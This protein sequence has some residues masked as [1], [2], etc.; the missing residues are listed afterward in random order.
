MEFIEATTDDIDILV[1][2]W[3][4]LA[5]AMEA[6]DELN[7][8]CY[9][10]VDEVSGGGFRALLDED[11]VTIYL[12][13]HEDKTI[14]YITLRKGHHPSREYSQYLRIVDL[15]I[16]EG[17]RNQGHGTEV[18]KRVKEIA[19]DQTCDYLKVSCEWQNEEARRFYRDTGFRPKQ[20]DYAQPLE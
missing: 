3:Y 16:D 9:A 20:V 6:Y 14:G 10:D 2:R 8:L 15:V 5:K 18:I 4:F 13:T 1:N 7:E 17:H 11:A 19:R 12:I